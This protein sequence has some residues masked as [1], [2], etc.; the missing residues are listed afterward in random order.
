MMA[1]ITTRAMMIHM[2]VRRVL[3]ETMFTTSG[4]RVPRLGG[5]YVWLSVL[6]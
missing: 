4:L 2:A 5:K 6:P 3:T 1:V